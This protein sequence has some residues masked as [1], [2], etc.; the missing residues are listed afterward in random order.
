MKTKKI[1]WEQHKSRPIIRGLIQDKLV[2]MII[3]DP[4]GDCVHFTKFYEERWN[5]KNKTFRVHK[6]AEKAK[7]YVQDLFETFILTCIEE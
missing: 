7:I 4:K 6:T 2:A 3:E 1:R 5:N